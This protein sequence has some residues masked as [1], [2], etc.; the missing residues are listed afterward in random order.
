MEILFSLKDFFK[1]FRE[2]LI[3]NNFYSKQYK[4]GKNL[5]AS[6]LDWVLISLIIFAFLLVTIYRALEHIGAT[7]I[8]TSFLMVIYLFTIIYINLKRRRKKILEINKKLS[9]EEIL[10]RLEKLSNR[11]YLLVIKEALEEYYNTQ[12]ALGGEYIDFIGKI[13]EKDY[14]IK[15]IRSSK[16]NIIVK[17]DIENYHNSMLDRGLEN[18]MIITNSYFH[19]DLKKEFDYILIDFDYMEEILKDIGKYPTKE[20]IHELI[21][22]EYQGRRE[23]LKEDFK[24]NKQN[25][26]YRF[27]LLG[28]VLLFISSFTNYSLYYKVSGFGLIFISVFLGLRKIIGFLRSSTE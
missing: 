1:N 20:E 25:K 3:L 17:R 12:L 6:L 13:N 14:G 24:H 23:N 28:I 18:G 21:L 22:A 26:V 4:D 7:V 9:Q 15:S 11:E 8:L 10:R 27:T 19:E 5:G 2:R 16:D